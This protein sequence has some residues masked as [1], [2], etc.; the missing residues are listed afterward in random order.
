MTRIILLL[1]ALCF[2]IKDGYAQLYN[3]KIEQSVIY[4]I[5]TENKLLDSIKLSYVNDFGYLSNNELYVVHSNVS[6]NAKPSRSYEFAK[7]TF[8]KGKFKK[9]ILSKLSINSKT[10]ICEDEKTGL[11]INN[12]RIYQKEAGFI[13]EY[14]YGE[15]KKQYYSEINS[16][17]LKNISVEI[18]KELKLI[19]SH[20]KCFS[21]KNKK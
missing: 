6:L 3:V 10:L 20:N 12:F 1:I 5:N 9:S 2:Y 8:D 17:I 16:K 18:C 7:Y 19:D 13:W 21:C 15:K 4:L 11:T 14:G